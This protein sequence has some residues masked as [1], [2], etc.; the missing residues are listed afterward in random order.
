MPGKIIHLLV[1]EGAEVLAGQ[2]ILVMEA[3]KMQNELKS[4]KK[5]IIKLQPVKAGDTVNSGDLLATV[6]GD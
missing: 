2:G 5:G 1:K 3:M 6:E 4:P